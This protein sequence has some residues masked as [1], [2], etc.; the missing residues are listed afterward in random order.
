MEKFWEMENLTWK[1][2]EEESEF[3]AIPIPGGRDSEK[4][5]DVS[6]KH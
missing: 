4:G 2:K 5:Q 6:N 3:L 1:S